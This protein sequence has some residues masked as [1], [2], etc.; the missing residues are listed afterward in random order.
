[1]AAWNREFNVSWRKTGLLKSSRWSSGFGRTR[2]LFI[3][4]YLSEGRDVSRLE[5][6][7]TLYLSSPKVCSVKFTVDSSQ[8]ASVSECCGHLVWRHQRGVREISPGPGC[9]Q[10][11]AGGLSTWSCWS[12]NP[13]GPSGFNF[14]QLGPTTRPSPINSLMVSGVCRRPS[15]HGKAM[16]PSACSLLRRTSSVGPRSVPRQS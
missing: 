16:L 4:I 15:R 8:E 12:C 9:P 11:L 7:H 13:L 6:F 5:S 3:K 14:S 1:M 10:T 2:R